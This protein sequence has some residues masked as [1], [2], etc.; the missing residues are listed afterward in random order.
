MIK[1]ANTVGIERTYSD[2]ISPQI[3]SHSMLKWKFSLRDQE[4]GKWGP[5]SMFLS[6]TVLEVLV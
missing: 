5:L 1:T 3:T 4:Q 2:I 6:N